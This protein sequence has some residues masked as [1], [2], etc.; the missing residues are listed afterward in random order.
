[1]RE[2]YGALSDAILQAAASA[3]MMEMGIVVAEETGWPGQ[4]RP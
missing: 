1:M 2:D 3:G 4:A